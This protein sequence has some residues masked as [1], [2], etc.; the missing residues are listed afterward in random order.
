[1]TRGLKA[2]LEKSGHRVEIIRFPFDYCSVPA[3]SELMDVCARQ[4]FES[5]NGYPVDKVIALQFPAY[6]VRHPDRTLWLMHQYRAVYDLFDPAQAPPPLKDLK[7]KIQTFDDREFQHFAARFTMCR[8][9]SD[10][11]ERFNRISAPPLYHPPAHE[12]QFY[13]DDSEGFIFFPS[14]LEQLKRQ[15]LLIRAMACTRTPVMAVIAGEGGRKPE[16]LQMIRRFR[17]EDKVC[18]AGFITENEKYALYA[19]SLGVFFGPYDED[20]GYITLEAMLSSKPVIT[21]TD[22]G[23]PLEF[24]AD[25]DTGFGVDPVP[26]LIAEKI[27]WLYANRQKAKEMGRA[28][29][30]AYLDKKITW[31]HVAAQLVQT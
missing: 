8:N 7:K 24:G 22:S 21:C 9:I 16:L 25:G 15:D 18:L 10:R 12:S 20:Y 13:C 27:D 1:M 23:G 17:L 29:R 2:A 11:L 14:R 19:R 3:I 28:G 30:H 6:Y 26:E 4:E 31:D 5:F